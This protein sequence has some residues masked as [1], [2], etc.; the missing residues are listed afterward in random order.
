MASKAFLE[1]AYLAYFGR[2]IDP[3]GVAAFVNSTETEVE[4]TFWASPESQALY[5]TSFGLQQIN[6]VYNMLFGRD[7]E[8]A[9]QAYW[10]NQIVIGNLTPAGAAIGILRGALNDDVIAV[11][12][13]LAASAAFTAGLDTTEEILGFAGDQAAAVARDFLSLITMTPATQDEVDAAIVAAVNAGIASGRNVHV[14]H[15]SG[16]LRRHRL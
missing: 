15:G 13:K 11:N 3:N 12:N 14:H 7:A 1:Q 6:M 4:N 10:A 16:S 8:P 5:G 2:P 9:G